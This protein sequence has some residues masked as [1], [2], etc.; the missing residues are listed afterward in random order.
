MEDGQPVDKLTSWKAEVMSDIPLQLEEDHNLSV[1]LYIGALTGLRTN[2]TKPTPFTLI[3]EQLWPMIS[4]FT[5]FIGMTSNYTL[6]STMI[7]TES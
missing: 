4:T 3:T 7:P 5:V 6:T 1:P 2:T